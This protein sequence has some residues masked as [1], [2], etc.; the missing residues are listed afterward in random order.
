MGQLAILDRDHFAVMTGGD[1]GLQAEIL[2]L[3]QAQAAI[4]LRLLT[5]NAPRQTW[6]DAAH[7]CKGSAKGL[8]LWRLADACGYAE[9]LG[10]E[11]VMEGPDVVHALSLVRSALDEALEA[12]HAIEPELAAANAG[13]RCLTACSRRPPQSLRP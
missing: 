7:T 8:G 6:A 10:R 13:V 1:A 2:D 5:P 9:A 12:I 11:G 4:W 3:F